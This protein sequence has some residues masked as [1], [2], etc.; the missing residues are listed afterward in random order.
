MLDLLDCAKAVDTRLSIRTG[1][2]APPEGLEALKEAG[3]F[4]VCLAP[5]S[6]A[7]W[8]DIPLNP[9]SKGD[10]TRECASRG[11]QTRERA[12]E[13]DKAGEH[14][15]KW[16]DA[17][18][19]VGLP[20]RLELQAP[21]DADLDIER[22][23]ARAAACGV[24]AADIC[25]DS[26]FLSRSP[27]KDVAASRKTIEQM[28]DLAAALAAKGIDVSLAGLPFC[29]VREDLRPHCLNSQQF[30][31]DHQQYRKKAYDLAVLLYGRWPSIAAKILGILIAQHTLHRTPLDAK[32]LP[33]LVRHPWFHSRAIAW[34]KLTRHLRLLRGVPKAAAADYEAR[35]KELRALQEKAL[36]ALGS[37]CGACSLRRICDHVTL[38]VERI[39]PGMSQVAQSGNLVYSPFHFSEERQ[40][41]YDAIDADRGAFNDDQAA[42]AR[43]ANDITTNRPPDKR[44]TPYEYTAETTVSAQY[45]G[46]L[47]WLAVTN[48]EQLSSPLA[49][50][51]PPCTVSVTFGG[52]M[53]EHIG[54]S[55]GRQCK[56]VCPME[57]CR[58]TLTLR[59]ESD[60]RYVLL[61]DGLPIRPSEFEGTVY[62]PL[63][64]GSSLELRLSIWNID[65]SILSQFVDIW[66]GEAPAEPDGLDRIRL[67]QRRPGSAGASPSRARAARAVARAKYSVIVVCTR[68]ARRLQAALQCLAHQEDFDMS[69]LEV[70]VCYVP[71]L[72]ATE[73]LIASMQMTYPDL[74]IVRSPFPEQCANAKGFII[75]ESRRMA[76][77][78]W[79]V[80]LDSDTLVP[81]RMF[82]E[83]EKVEKNANFIA[84]DGRKMLTPETTAR[85]LLGEADPWRQW[86][87]LFDGPGEYRPREAHGVP[88]GFFQCVR[89]SCMDVVQYEEMDHFE[90]ADMRFGVQIWEKFGA[91]TRLLGFP[92]L[93]LDHGGSQWYGTVKHR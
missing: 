27:C 40:R 89:A 56:V 88:V 85:I 29:M 23:S 8:N 24:V 93:H 62:A 78:E 82:A 69:K 58:H 20:V 77:G 34:N 5:A 46:A 54:F 28:N 68:Y 60:G 9:P 87:E 18:R 22:L 10:K 3:L 7:G 75:N 2:A 72:D 73:D 45:E 84:P 43:K 61:R 74:R 90:G 41:Y 13:G 12:S 51:T 44:V 47:H 19:A 35:E 4:D 39:L 31:Q 70:I 81:P 79:I 57:A 11:D 50:I 21:F 6:L 86:Q 17:C 91:P 37:I 83:I 32:L 55:F 63:R 71:G 42:I 67:Q 14:F 25:L 59:I 66:E 76:S 49:T 36:K 33:W 64:L 1:C 92:V 65:T 26:P 80:L 15:D 48:L 16:L 38:L 53:A 30:F 52:G